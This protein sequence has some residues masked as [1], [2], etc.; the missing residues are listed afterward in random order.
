LFWKFRGGPSDS[1]ILGNQL[2]ISTWPG[3][4]APVITDGKVFFAAAATIL[5]SIQ[6][7]IP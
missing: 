3:R 4:G 2:L 6:N 7:K 5:P 1:K